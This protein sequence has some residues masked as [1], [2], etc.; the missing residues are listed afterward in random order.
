MQETKAKS[1]K[2]KKKNKQIPQPEKGTG[3]RK[4]TKTTWS[5]RYSTTR[6]GPPYCGLRGTTSPDT[7]PIGFTSHASAM[8]IGSTAECLAVARARGQQKVVERWAG[9]RARPGLST[10]AGPPGGG[11][12]QQHSSFCFLWDPAPTASPQ[13]T[14]GV[15]E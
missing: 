14:S 15:P 5:R 4:K 13:P 2:K 9:A 3:A 10:K 1:T 12:Q 11:R 8:V 6:S 7:V